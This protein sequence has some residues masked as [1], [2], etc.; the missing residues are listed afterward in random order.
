MDEISNLSEEQLDDMRV[1][2]L[3]CF[4]EQDKAEGRGM[5]VYEMD[6]SWEKLHWRPVYKPQTG[7]ERS[8]Y[9]PLIA[10]RS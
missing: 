4:I 8:Q 1:W 9:N 5:R 6:A 2:E 3:H 7:E 10:A